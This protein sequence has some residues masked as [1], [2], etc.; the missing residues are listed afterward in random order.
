MNNQVLAN[1]INK[2]RLKDIIDY[3]DVDDLRTEVIKDYVKGIDKLHV[4]FSVDVEKF[5]LKK[6]AVAE[7]E[8][9]FREAFKNIVTIG[10]T[11][12]P[13]W[14]A[15]DVLAHVL[16]EAGELSTAIQVKRGALK[17]NLAEDEFGECADVINCIV[18][19]VSQVNKDKTP[20]QIVDKLTE[21]LIKKSVKW[22][23]ILDRINKENTNG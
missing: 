20:E 11:A 12:A 5:R 15:A 19:A 18:D 14:T 6:S 21:A 23:G 10:R 2:E 8:S 7:K 13:S 1:A 4:T 17:K 22:K 3:V 16:Q 9:T